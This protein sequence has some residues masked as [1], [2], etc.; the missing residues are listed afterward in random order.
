MISRF[1]RNAKKCWFQTSFSIAKAN[2][3]KRAEFVARFQD[4]FEQFCQGQVRFIYI[5]E[6]H[7]HQEMAV[8][9]RWSAVGEADWVPSHC[10][11]LQ[12]RLDWYGAYDF[13]HGQCLIWHQGGCDSDR[14]VAFLQYL[15]QQW[16]LDPNQQTCIIWDGAPWHSKS[17][18]VRQEA[19]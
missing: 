17:A 11:T 6:A 1:A 7:L 19:E 10:P 9:Y 3:Q 8:G 12:N 15:A 13:S 18:I 4:W 14:T 5:D 2:P 16:P